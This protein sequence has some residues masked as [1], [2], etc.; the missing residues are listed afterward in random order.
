ML[1]FPSDE[2]SIDYGGSQEG[3]GRWQGLMVKFYGTCLYCFLSLKV[4]SSV[5]LA[6]VS[7]FLRLLVDSFTWIIFLVRE[8]TPYQR[9]YKNY[10]FCKLN[11][12]ERSQIWVPF[13]HIS[14]KIRRHGEQAWLSTTPKSKLFT[15]TKSREIGNWLWHPTGLLME[16]KQRRW[17]FEDTTSKVWNRTAQPH[18]RPTSKYSL[19]R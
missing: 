16:L 5:V 15:T 12:L 19:D 7:N 2:H 14:S 9:V 4:L 10:R 13:W 1:G 18:S 8:F 11:L 17:N 3:V 6:Y